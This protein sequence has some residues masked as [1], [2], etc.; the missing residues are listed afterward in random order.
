MGGGGTAHGAE[1]RRDATR[2][3][4]ARRGGC[5]AVRCG[6]VRYGAVRCGGGAPRLLLLL[7]SRG[8]VPAQSI[9][10]RQVGALR[11]LA[12]RL[13]SDAVGHVLSRREE[14]A[15]LTKGGWGGRRR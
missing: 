12:A 3:G 6:A 11:R 4:A 7:A 8:G 1:L 13:A 14:A 2:R 9:E 10:H 15:H 5:G